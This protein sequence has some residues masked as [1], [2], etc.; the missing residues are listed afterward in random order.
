MKISVDA[1]DLIEAILDS[2]KIKEIL[3]N[4]L[5]HQKEALIGGRILD[6]ASD[7]Q[8]EMIEKAKEEREA[9]GA[10]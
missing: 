9:C 8:Y 5:I 4:G 1:E 7:L 6:L 2:D 3:L 10:I